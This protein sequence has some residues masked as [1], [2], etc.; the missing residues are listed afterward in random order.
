[1]LWNSFKPALI[2]VLL[3]FFWTFFIR[4]VFLMCVSFDHNFLSD[5][6]SRPALKRLPLKWVIKIVSINW[7]RD[8]HLAWRVVVHHSKI[9]RCS[10]SHEAWS[11]HYSPMITRWSLDLFKV[12][13]IFFFSGLGSVAS[14]ATASLARSLRDRARYHFLS[15]VLAITP[16]QL[17]EVDLEQV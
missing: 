3:S 15:K 5:E 1:M 13:L 11:V 6:H 10:W 9:T 14:L 8:G 17:H 12:L 7:S 4:A 16:Y 2:L